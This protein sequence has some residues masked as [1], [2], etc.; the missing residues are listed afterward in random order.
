MRSHS[1]RHAV[2]PA[3][4]DAGLRRECADHDVS[5]VITIRL[6][7]AIDQAGEMALLRR[8]ADL[9]DGISADA[10]VRG[11]YAVA[12]K[13]DG[14]PVT[15]VDLAIE[16][17]LRDELRQALPADAFEGEEVGFV[18]GTS[19]R[20]W[21]VDGIDGT[22]A[23]ASGRPEW[24]TLIAVVEDEVGVG[25]VITSPAL[26]RRWWARPGGGALMTL[27]D[28][29]EQ[30]LHV[31]DGEHVEFDR[32]AS[33][34]PAPTL[35][36]PMHERAMRLARIAGET[37]VRPSWGRQV[38]HGAVLVATGVLDGFALFGG[39]PWDHAA[40]QALV[41]G[42]GGAFTDLT[43]ARTVCGSGGLY[44]NGRIHADLVHIL[45]TPS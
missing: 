6:M 18:G 39:G 17:R 8:L 3:V 4:G 24:S 7:G 22:V 36:G 15:D 2:Q 14:S 45:N 42:A 20:T 34:P 9:A 21:I 1:D 11:D 25:G 23:F 40:A 32:L 41:E 31:S 30:T 29:G 16:Q 28:G 5:V 26:G 44:T 37:F 35:V 38:P 33:W 19:G 27:E 10:F 43:G 12:T 13:A